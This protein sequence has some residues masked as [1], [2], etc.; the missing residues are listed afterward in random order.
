LEAKGIYYLINDLN[1]TR[2]PISNGYVKVF[3]SSI[4]DRL[5]FK[6]SV[7]IYATVLNG[8]FESINQDVI[9]VNKKTASKYILSPT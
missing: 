2:L 6:R 8:F 9:K 4:Q 7:G 1:E 3:L 5:R